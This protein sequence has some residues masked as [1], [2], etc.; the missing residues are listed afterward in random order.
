[1]S[2]K[3]DDQEGGSKLENNEQKEG[4]YAAGGFQAFPVPQTARHRV[5]DACGIMYRP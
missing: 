4:G 5:K 3:E 1:M 2:E